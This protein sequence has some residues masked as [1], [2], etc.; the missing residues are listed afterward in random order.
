MMSLIKFEGPPAFWGDSGD[1]SVDCVS[2]GTLLFSPSLTKA[3]ND[4]WILNTVSV[5]KRSRARSSRRIRPSIR[6]C[7]KSRGRCLDEVSSVTR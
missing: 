4:R 7:L 5:Y 2:K 3:L 1:V 6:L